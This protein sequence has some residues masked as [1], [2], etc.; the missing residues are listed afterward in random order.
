M[1]SFSPYPFFLYLF[2]SMHNTLM[3]SLF[4]QFFVVFNFQSL[5]I[6]LQLPEAD[7]LND[8]IRQVESCRSRCVLI[9]KDL[10]SLKVVPV[11]LFI[12]VL[13]IDVELLAKTAILTGNQTVSL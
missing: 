10:D 2:P 12:S 3:V 4:M 6:Q 8:L 7:K 5:E 9:L 13:A 1:I 11:D